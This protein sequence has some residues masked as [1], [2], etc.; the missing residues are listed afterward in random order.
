MEKEITICP[1]EFTPPGRCFE[2][3]GR[4]IALDTEMTLMELNDDGIPLNEETTVKCRG[5]C[6]NCGKQYNMVRTGSGYMT[7]SNP[8][9]LKQMLI[10]KAVLAKNRIEQSRITNNPLAI[11]NN[12]KGE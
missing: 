4:L 10:N 8:L 7:Y 6:K 11:E 9:V 3:G 12:E 1:I 5:V 2:C